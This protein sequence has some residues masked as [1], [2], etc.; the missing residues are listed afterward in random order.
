MDYIHKPFSPAVVKAR[1]HTHLVLREAREQ[2]AR[3][4]LFIN[5]EL[6]MAREIQLSILPQEIPR[7]KG[8][9]ITARYLPM[10]SVAGDFYDFILVDEK[11]LGI[12]VADVSGHGLA[13]ALIA[14]MLQVALAAQSSHASDPGRVL[15]GLNQSL[16]GKFKHHFVTAIYVFMDLEKKSVSYAGAGHPPLLLWRASTRSASEVVQNGLLL[17]LFPAQTYSVIEMPVEPG[18]KVVLF[19]DGIV[20]TESPS[21]QEFGLDLFKGFLESNHHLKANLFA[22]ALLDELSNWSEHPKGQGQKDDITFL[23]IDF[24]VSEEQLIPTEHIGAF[25][26]IPELL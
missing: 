11:H 22:D 2:L 8:L 17:G 4:L 20:E 24:S 26:T 12:L 3:Q 25:S 16:C 18:D 15:A 6:E 21:E 14:S 1:V 5:S 9:E 13:A 19:T 10:S 7:I 23:T